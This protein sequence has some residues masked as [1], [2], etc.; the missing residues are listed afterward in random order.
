MW[1]SLKENLAEG[2]IVFEGM[3]DCII[4]ISHENT[5]C[6]SYAQMIKHYIFAGWT[7]EE[8]IL[9]LEEHVC[10]D[11]EGFVLVY[12]TD[13]MFSNYGNGE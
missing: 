1:D 9:Y 11:V 6:Y 7:C 10:H 12:E 8:A 13:Y 5:L 2:S 3:D 4:G